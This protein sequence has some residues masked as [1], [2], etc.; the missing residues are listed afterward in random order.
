M[1]RPDRVARRDVEHSFLK[2]STAGVHT[3]PSNDTLLT[4]RDVACDLGVKPLGEVSKGVVA[5]K[6]GRPALAL[7]RVPAASVEGGT[8]EGAVLAPVLAAGSWR[9][10]G[11]PQS[12]LQG[13]KEMPV[14]DDRHLQIIPKHRRLQVAAR[15]FAASRTQVHLVVAGQSAQK[16]VLKLFPQRGAPEALEL[17]S[18]LRQVD[19]PAR[20]MEGPP[21]LAQESLLLLLLLLLLLHIL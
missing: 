19:R 13:E 4:Q 10:Q 9:A 14:R 17:G 11:E 3:I 7:E 21:R 1:G 6:A 5:A 2:D 8:A 18:R 15:P 16:V 12:V 20:R